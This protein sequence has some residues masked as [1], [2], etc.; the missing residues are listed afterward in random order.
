MYLFDLHCDTVTRLNSE[1]K[2]FRSNDAHIA[3]DRMSGLQWCQCFAIFMPDEYRGQ[4]AIDYFEDNYRFFRA[5]MDANRDC[6][7][8]V[9]T[10]AEI[11]TA[12]AEGK[13]AALLTV[14]GGSALAGDLSRVQRLAECGVRMLTLTWNGSNEIASGNLTEYGFTEFGKQAVRELENAGIVLDVS[15]LNDK[16]FWELTH[17]ATRPFIA[18][19]SNSRAVCNHPRNLTDEQF[20][21]I[22]DH[23]GL[24]GINFC[25]H[26]ISESKDPTFRQFADHIAH[27]L[28]L[29][30]ED[31]LALGSDYDGTDVPSWLDPAEKIRGLYPLI[32]DEFG[33][34]IAEKIFF[35]NA[36]HF[37]NRYDN[38]ANNA[39]QAKE[40]F[41]LAGSCAP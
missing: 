2:N 4:S 5:Q 34:Q 24:V 29:G 19:H 36:Y 21:Y 6:I 30:G 23:G 10:S 28:D 40:D 25:I 9:R 8:Q 37:L 35:K 17:L 38:P 18:T 39:V 1:G 22:V 32:C 41:L 11:E 14:E 33:E 7:T 20:G 15:H 16:G 3:L 12:L 27:F 13:A 26:F 31:V